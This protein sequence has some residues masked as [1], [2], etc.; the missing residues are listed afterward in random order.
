M[1]TR[2]EVLSRSGESSAPTQQKQ[3][4]KLLKH[5]PDPFLLA[6]HKGLQ[7]LLNDA[8]QI[9]VMSFGKHC[10]Q[11]TPV[12]KL[13]ELNWRL[14]MRSTHVARSNAIIVVWHVA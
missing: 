10:E 4:L 8:K 1:L 7:K 2:I 14:G 9:A 3:R 11:R 13:R 12:P 5:A 6:G